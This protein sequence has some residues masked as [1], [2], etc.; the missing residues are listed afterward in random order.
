MCV[1]V[2][3]LII[4]KNFITLIFIKGNSQITNLVLAPLMGRIQGD[5][6][7]FDLVSKQHIFRDFNCKMDT[8]SK[9]IVGLLIRNEVRNGSAMP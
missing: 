6:A 3:Y 5:R 2:K 7:A 8:L 4:D 1:C 9:E